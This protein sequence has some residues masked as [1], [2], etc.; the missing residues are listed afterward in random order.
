AINAD[1][2]PFVQATLLGRTPVSARLEGYVSPV[3]RKSILGQRDGVCQV[4]LAFEYYL[5]TQTLLSLLPFC[6]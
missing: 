1:V 6:Q 4:K 2:L 5:H 3:K